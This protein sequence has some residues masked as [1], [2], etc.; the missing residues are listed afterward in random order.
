MNR[1]N[2]A[3]IGYPARHD[4]KMSTQAKPIDRSATVKSPTTRSH[5]LPWEMKGNPFRASRMPVI[6]SSSSNPNGSPS[7]PGVQRQNSVQTRYM[8][9]LLNLD[10]IPRLHNILSSFFTWILLAGFIIFPGTFTSIA[11]FQ[12]DPTVQQSKAASELLKDVKDVPLLYIAGFCS[13][14]GGLGMIWLWFR[15]RENY[16]WLLNKIFL[17]GCLNSFAGLISTFVNVYSQQSGNWSVTAWVTA[18]VTGGVMIITGGLFC[19]YNFWVLDKVKKRHEQEMEVWNSD[20][21]GEG[22]REKIERKAHAP[23]LEP[24]SV[25]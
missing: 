17:P 9:M 16:V 5:H 24:G 6:A 20:H 7:R 15:W 13:G 4:S 19:L 22:I 25:V 1:S 23:A 18:A 3:P 10:T 11:K 14:I 2:T 21:E 8:S 12:D